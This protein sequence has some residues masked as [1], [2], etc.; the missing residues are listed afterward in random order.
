V[1]WGSGV[2]ETGQ[3]LT[4]IGR[5]KQVVLAGR[6][7]GEMEIAR[8]SCGRVC[9][10][11]GVIVEVGQAERGNGCVWGSVSEEQSG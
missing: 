9:E 5:D 11:C 3:T 10:T 2:R 7:V 1:R 6:G 4:A 8:H